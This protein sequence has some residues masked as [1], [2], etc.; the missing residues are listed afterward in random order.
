[1]PRHA[2]TASLRRLVE[3]GFATR[4]RVTAV[5]FPDVAGVPRGAAL[6]DGVRTS[7]RAP[8]GVRGALVT[9]REGRVWGVGQAG[10]EV[11]STCT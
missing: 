3:R 6:N 8:R 4:H 5:G 7:T 2:L 1:M 9:G 11:V 10:Q